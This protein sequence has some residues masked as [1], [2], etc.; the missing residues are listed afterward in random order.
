MSSYEQKVEPWDKK[1]QYVVFACDPYETIAF[2]IPNVEIATRGGGASSKGFS[3]CQAAWEEGSK[4]KGS[5]VG[6]RRGR[7]W[8]RWTDAANLLILV[9]ESWG[10]TTNSRPGAPLAHRGL[11][12]DSQSSPRMRDHQGV[13]WADG[14]DV[15]HR[16]RRRT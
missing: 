4:V 12:E 15:A 2:K 9:T 16:R 8:G 14:P 6:V 5:E 7:R 1:Y 13:E 3:G 10:R 11:S